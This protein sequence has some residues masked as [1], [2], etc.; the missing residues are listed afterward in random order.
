MTVLFN[1]LD[2][3]YIYKCLHSRLQHTFDIK[4]HVRD[5]IKTS[6][7]IFKSSGMIHEEYMFAQN[8]KRLCQFL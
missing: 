8:A 3:H 5:K 7:Y 1:R 4:E 2:F 6:T